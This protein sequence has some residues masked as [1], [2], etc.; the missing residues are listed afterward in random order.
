M[1]RGEEWEKSGKS[2]HLANIMGYKALFCKNYPK[3]PTHL[4]ATQ[5]LHA[6]RGAV[7]LY[8]MA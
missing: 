8:H 5:L 3:R 4:H 7:V 6:C 1:L 2:K